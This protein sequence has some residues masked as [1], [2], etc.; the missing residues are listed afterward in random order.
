ML[1]RLPGLAHEGWGLKA[2]DAHDAA[3]LGWGLKARASCQLMLMMLP[4]L[5]SQSPGQLPADAHDAMLQGESQ[6]LAGSLMKH[7]PVPAD[8][9][10][11]QLVVQWRPFNICLVQ[12]SLIQ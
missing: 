3:G 2:A 5:G 7:N 10:T 11:L 8:D 6:S 12:S 4:G 1:M 9:P